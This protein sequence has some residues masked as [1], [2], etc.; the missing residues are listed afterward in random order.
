MTAL[1]FIKDQAIISCLHIDVDDSSSQMS[2]PNRVLPLLPHVSNEA[3]EHRWSRPDPLK[4]YKIMPDETSNAA[5]KDTK[6]PTPTPN[7]SS[8]AEDRATP[9]PVDVDLEDYE[10]PKYPPPR[11]TP[12]EPESAEE[13]TRAVRP[14][15]TH[16][17][18]DSWQGESPSSICLCQPDPKVPRPRNGMYPIHRTQILGHIPMSL[19]KRCSHP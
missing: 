14:S 19:Y 7:S 1:S 8:P 16:R 18:S 9:S 3:L 11:S 10:S 15:T 6:A 5:S 17:D 13:T 2:F 4:A 12:Q